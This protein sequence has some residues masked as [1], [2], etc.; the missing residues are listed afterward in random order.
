MLALMTNERKTLCAC[1]ILALGVVVGIASSITNSVSLYGVVD[2]TVLSVVTQLVTGVINSFVVWFAVPFMLGYLLSR[3]WKQSAV[4]G[5]AF[6]VAAIFSYS[7]HSSVTSTSRFI[8]ETSVVSMMTPQLDWLAI[9][10]VGGVIGAVTG[11][12][13]RKKPSILLVLVLV[14]IAELARRGAL[15][16]QSPISAGQNIIF[17]VV[18]LGIVAYVMRAV[19]GR[20]SVE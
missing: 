11:F 9:A 7:V 3:S 13:A 6:M 5:A 14:V 12:L 8:E 17:I 19:R 4:A 18:A 1:L 10:V 15:S 2:L 16:W 20:K